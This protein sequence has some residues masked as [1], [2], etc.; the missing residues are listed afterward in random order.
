LIPKNAMSAERHVA[1]YPIRVGEW[2]E[3]DRLHRFNYA[4]LS[5]IVGQDACAENVLDWGCGNG[6]WSLG[7]FPD[8]EI[9]GVEIDAKTLG[10][11]ELN[12]KGNLAKFNG[13]LVGETGALQP[14]HYDVALA[15]GLIELINYDD[16][17]K[18]FGVIFRALKPGG[19]LICTLHNWRAFSALYLLWITQGG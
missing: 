17:V 6:L 13:L 4:A 3:Q 15:M 14:N 12:A 16:F 10:F 1:R 5:Q 8:A 7:L 18:V 9:T 11:A 19:K 2:F